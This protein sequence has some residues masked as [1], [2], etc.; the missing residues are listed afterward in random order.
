MKIFIKEEFEYIPT[1]QGNRE[2]KE[3]DQVK[4]TLHFP[5]AS[6]AYGV[7]VNGTLDAKKEWLLICKDVVILTRIRKCSIK[8]A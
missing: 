4:V 2:E 7:Y 3:A 6:E 8:C 5:S 1:Y